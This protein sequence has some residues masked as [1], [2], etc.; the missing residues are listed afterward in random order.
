[1]DDIGLGF[2]NFDYLG[3]YRVTDNG[4]PIDPSGD[5]DG[6][7]FADARGLSNLVASRPEAASCIVRKM[8]RDAVG[9]VELMGEEPAIAT[10]T[11]QFDTANHRIAALVT[12]LVTSDAFRLVG[13][14]Q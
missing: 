3:K 13:P 12:A 4:L 1:M 11:G 6:A 2:E 9:H 10:L 7:K 8:Y 14:S 5:L